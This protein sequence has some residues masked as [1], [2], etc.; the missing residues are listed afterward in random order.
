MTLPCDY[1]QRSLNTFETRFCIARLPPS[2]IYIKRMKLYSSVATIIPSHEHTPPLS[3]S[4]LLPPSKRTTFFPAQFEGSTTSHRQWPAVFEKAFLFIASSGL[5]VTREVVEARPSVVH[6]YKRPIC[7]F[8]KPG[9]CL[10]KKQEGWIQ[11]RSTRSAQKQRKG[12]LVRR[13]KKRR[14]KKKRV[15]FALP[16]CLDIDGIDWDSWDRRMSRLTILR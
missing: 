6:F 16:Y 7:A 2:N 15:R 13:P 14:S 8:Q 3:T 1:Y 10:D 5:L 11:S 12:I 9:L 4:P